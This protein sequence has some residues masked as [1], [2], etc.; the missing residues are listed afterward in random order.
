MKLLLF[1]GVLLLLSCVWGYFLGGFSL[2]LVSVAFII[3][4]G[5]IVLAR[6]AM[7]PKP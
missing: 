3:G 5:L 6:G 7:R 4:L 1:F 2:V